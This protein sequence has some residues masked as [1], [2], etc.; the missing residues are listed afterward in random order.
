MKTYCITR[1]ERSLIHREVDYS[2]K[3]SSKQ[4]AL[5]KLKRMEYEERIPDDEVFEDEWKPLQIIKVCQEWEIDQYGLLRKT[6]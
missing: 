5:E 1:L 3:A 2:I 6:R 4:Q